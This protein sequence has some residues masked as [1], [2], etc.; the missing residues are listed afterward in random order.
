MEENQNSTTP[1]SPLVA[2][3][4][5]SINLDDVKTL[6]EKHYDQLSTCGIFFDNKTKK[7]WVNK[8]LDCNCFMIYARSLVIHWQEDPR[9]WEWGKL[10]ESSG[11]W[12][13]VAELIRVCW[14]EM[15]GKLD[16]RYLSP[17]V[18]Y[19]VSFH[20]MLKNVYYRYSVKVSL[21]LEGMKYQEHEMNFREMLKETWM[22]IPVGQFVA[23]AHDVGAREMEFRLWNTDDP[24]W[25]EGLIVKGASI[26]PL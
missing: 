6:R 23:P 18:M 5:T 12:I 14:L 19:G 17:G 15:R 26:K 22:E 7:F 11:T 8:K 21:K 25:K 10:K 24:Y 9:Y 13:E 16:T 20:V 1:P 2:T 3:Q 4:Q